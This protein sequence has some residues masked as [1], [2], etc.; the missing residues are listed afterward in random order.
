MQVH[1]CPKRDKMVTVTASLDPALG[2]ISENVGRGKVAGQSGKGES[3]KKWKRD[4]S[5]IRDP[6]VGEY[7]NKIG[8]PPP[9]LGPSMV[10][11]TREQESSPAGKHADTNAMQEPT[12]PALGTLPQ[13]R[14]TYSPLL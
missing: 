10:F 11:Y 8:T 7:Y 14:N 6:E 2:R 4:K 12:P 1:G 9:L 13:P 5:G 3:C